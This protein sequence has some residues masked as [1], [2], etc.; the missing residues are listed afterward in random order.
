MKRIITTINQKWLEG[1]KIR[2]SLL[3]EEMQK[4]VKEINEIPAYLVGYYSSGEYHPFN[5]YNDKETADAYCGVFA[6]NVTHPDGNLVEWSIRKTTIGAGIDLLNKEEDEEMNS[7]KQEIKYR[8]KHKS[9]GQYVSYLGVEEYEGDALLLKKVDAT[10]FVD[11]KE[12]AEEFHFGW[13]DNNMLLASPLGRLELFYMKF[14]LEIE[15]VKE[16]ESYLFYSEDLDT[17]FDY[18]DIDTTLNGATSFR[19]DSVPSLSTYDLK[20]SGINDK[21]IIELFEQHTNFYK[22][23]VSDLD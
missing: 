15:E 2:M 13:E 10:E 1:G 4:A 18:I 20:N 17:Y 11:N 3:H 6:M 16:E 22:V 12:D 21:E 5:I 23:K 19:L 9:T 8:L 7:N 14:F